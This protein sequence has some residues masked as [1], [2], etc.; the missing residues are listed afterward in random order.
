MAKLY[1]PYIEGK[2]P[3]QSGMALKVPFRLNRA[4]SIKEI[5]KIVARIKTVSTGQWLGTITTSYFNTEINNYFA[6]FKDE[7]NEHI[8]SDFISENLKIGQ[9]YK[10]QLAFEN[11]QG[12]L[13]YYSSIGVFKYTSEPSIYIEGMSDDKLTNLYTYI[14][15]YNQKD[16][17]PTEKVY[18]Y[19]FDVYRGSEIIATSGLQL[20]DSTQDEKTYESRDTW[21][22]NQS[23]DMGQIYQIKYSVNTI[24]GMSAYRSYNITNTE[25]DV[26]DILKCEI[27]A[28]NDYKNGCINIK[29]KLKEFEG[30]KTGGFLISRSSSEDG[31]QTW[32]D[33]MKFTL[34]GDATLPTDLWTDY[35]V[36]QGVGYKYSIQ[37]FNDSGFYSTRIMNKEPVIADFEDMFLYDGKRQLRISFNPKITS[38]KTTLLETKIDTIGGKY[39][40]V[41]RNGNVEYKEFPISGLISYLSDENELFM[42][43]IELGFYEEQAHR[44]ST[45]AIHNSNFTTR[46]TALTS[47]NIMAERNFKM[48]VLAWLTNGKPK[49]FKSPTEGNFI[50]RLMNTSFS[51]NDTVGRMLH[52][53][54]STAYEIAD[55]DFKNLIDLGFIQDK[56]IESKIFIMET[57]SFKDC[58]DE[59]GLT[60]YNNY[61]DNYSGGVYTA[62]FREV[63]AGTLFN[64]SFLN[65]KSPVTISIPSNGIYTVNIYD[66][67]LIGISVK[68]LPYGI[69]SLTGYIDVGYYNSHQEVG[70]FSAVR[71]V[72][73]VDKIYQ[74]IGYTSNLIDDLDNFKF[75]VGYFYYLKAETRPSKRVYYNKGKYYND[76]KFLDEIVISPNYLYQVV[77]RDEKWFDGNN[78]NQT[79]FN[80][81][82][83]AI[84]IKIDEDDKEETI[85]IGN[86]DNAGSYVLP[87]MKKITSLWVGS[88]IVIDCIYQEKEYIY[89]AEED[90]KNIASLKATWN[91]KK[92]ELKELIES[93]GNE[94]EIENKKKEV[95]NSYNIFLNS[96]RDSI[97]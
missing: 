22:L 89:C 17:D 38:F 35:T 13:G 53:F 87:N 32:N 29:L 8:I 60:R 33:I 43:N 79:L 83:Y 68:E 21:V 70:D 28:E 77:N 56:S 18:S 84:K 6:D 65:G 73:I 81:P 71:K 59:L 14:G 52:T 78:K 69:Q 25:L 45:S 82:S 15:V 41:F 42:S 46:S 30:L 95:E 92:N 66:Q 51:P 90:D 61:L 47:E 2:I 58:N 7:N 55:Y 44:H 12:E 19:Q 40:F 74:Q 96:L 16:K 11:E 20:H 34:L 36:K 31:Y 1:P 86:Y 39:P 85:Y 91:Q 50:V 9:Y 63:P 49:I 24:N 4:V 97:D 27:F 94:I 76:S 80:S 67:P 5:K 37:R 3:A 48:N 57:I 23:L 26:D 64:L 10:I 72:A 93:N 62:E 54:S 88:G 75:K